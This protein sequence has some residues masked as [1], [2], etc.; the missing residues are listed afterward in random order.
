MARYCDTNA[1]RSNL[2]ILY[3]CMAE[4]VQEEK[5][6]MLWWKMVECFQQDVVKC[7][8]RNLESIENNLWDSSDWCFEAPAIHCLPP[9]F[10][11]S[12]QMRDSIG[13]LPAGP[14]ST[15]GEHN[16]AVSHRWVSCQLPAG[17]CQSLYSAEKLILWSRLTFYPWYSLGASG[18]MW[19]IYCCNAITEASQYKSLLS[20]HYACNQMQWWPNHFLQSYA[21]DKDS[22]MLATF[23]EQ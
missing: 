5:V 14:R 8:C 16:F 10:W 19:S 12:K 13:G 9:R 22:S 18:D 17:I 6:V 20:K 4:Q 11:S 1:S 7:W 23:E 3:Q 15:V 21:E 2:R